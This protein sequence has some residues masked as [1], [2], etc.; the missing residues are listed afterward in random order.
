MTDGLITAGTD[1][2]FHVISVENL[3]SQFQD[4]YELDC[5]TDPNLPAL[6]PESFNEVVAALQTDG[7]TYVLIPEFGSAKAHEVFQAVASDTF[8]SLFGEVPPEGQG[9]CT[10]CQS[11][12]SSDLSALLFPSLYGPTD[13][14]EYASRLPWFLCYGP[15]SGVQIAAVVICWIVA[16]PNT[17]CI[18]V[19]QI[20]FSACLYLC[21]Q[22]KPLPDPSDFF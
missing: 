7:V 22:G 2:W 15:C 13:D 4:W 12:G 16:D 11:G 1:T 5:Q 6:P 17:N 3:V 14:T 21:S 18:D 8:V 9:D 10:P 19:G 20:A